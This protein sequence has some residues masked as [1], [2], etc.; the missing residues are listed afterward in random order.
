MKTAGCQQRDPLEA[1][2]LSLYI[3]TG[4]LKN[5]GTYGHGKL[6]TLG[7][8][9]DM[10]SIMH[11]HNKDFSK[12]GGNTIEAIDDPKRVLGKDDL[13]KIDIKQINQ[14]YDCDKKRSGKSTVFHAIRISK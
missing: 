2:F 5:F 7:A 6:D 10:N 14:L 11:Y 1:S 8:P 4:A 3:F 13:S 9:Y 12:N